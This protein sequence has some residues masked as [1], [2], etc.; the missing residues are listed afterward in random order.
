[1]I[2]NLAVTKY[3]KL[4]LQSKKD[5]GSWNKMQSSKTIASILFD[6]EGKSSYRARCIREWADYYII[7]SNFKQF[8][9]GKHIKTFTIIIDEGVQDILRLHLRKM[10]KIERT[11]LN[12]MHLLNDKVLAEIK[13]NIPKAPDSVNEDTARRWMRVL[14]FYPATHSKGYFV[15]GHEREDVVEYRKNF[16][17][18]MM[19]YQRYFS[20][21]EGEDMETQIYMGRELEER[22]A[23]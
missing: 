3:F 6:K 7:N 1:M 5:S 12:F 18:E 8:K 10:D 15:D 20:H 9:Q 13:V 21:W 17:E 4:I 22:I 11:P 16:L 23:P 2:Q 14:G 19:Q